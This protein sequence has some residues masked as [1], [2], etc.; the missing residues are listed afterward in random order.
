MILVS[1]NNTRITGSFDLVYCVAGIADFAEDGS[2]NW[3]G[4]SSVDWDSQRTVTRG[5]Q[6]VYV[7][8]DGE[9]Y[10]RS[11]CRLMTE[12]AFADLEEVCD[13]AGCENVPEA[14]SVCNA[15]LPGLVAEEAR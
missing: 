2:P 5:G 6:E 13:V 8:D 4:G 9:E 7:D 15:C 1:Q 11:E 12:D 3:E 10:L 14:G